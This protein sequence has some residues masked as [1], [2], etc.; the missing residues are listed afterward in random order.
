MIMVNIIYYI[1]YLVNKVESF[2]LL[3]NVDE[4]KIMK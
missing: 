4:T 2:Y 3:V 1:S